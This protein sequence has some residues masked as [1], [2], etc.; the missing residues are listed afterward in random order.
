M[1]AARRWEG[2]RGEARERGF[3]SDSVVGCGSVECEC[4][5]EVSVSVSVSVRVKL[6]V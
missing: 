3:G 2:V 5:C 1:L 4:E 6:G